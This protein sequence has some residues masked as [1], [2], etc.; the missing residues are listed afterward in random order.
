MTRFRFKHY[1]DWNTYL[2]RFEIYAIQSIAD[3]QTIYL[4]DKNEFAILRHKDGVRW[5]IDETQEVARKIRFKA[6]R[7]EILAIYE[8]VK[9]LRRMKVNYGEVKK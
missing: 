2:T 9:D 8:D 3:S 6:I 7:D 5:N 4:L 1:H